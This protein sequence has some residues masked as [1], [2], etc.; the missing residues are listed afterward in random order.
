MLFAAATIVTFFST[1]A[2]LYHHC[3]TFIFPEL[4]SPSLFPISMT[5]A[6]TL[7]WQ[8]NLCLLLLPNTKDQSVTR[9]SWFCFLYLAPPLLN[10]HH[11]CSGLSILPPDLWPLLPVQLIQLLVDSVL[12][13]WC[14]AIQVIKIIIIIVVVAITPTLLIPLSCCSASRLVSLPLAP[15]THLS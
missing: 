13:A 12:I 7:F 6:F 11:P 9:S 14:F 5:L 3:L 15:S 1:S 10:C 8:Q 4:L 2:S